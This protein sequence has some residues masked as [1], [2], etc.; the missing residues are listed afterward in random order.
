MQ[1]VISENDRAV[2]A[3]KSA[4]SDL[5]YAFKLKLEALEGNDAVSK[6]FL[7]QGY[8]GLRCFDVAKK[9]FGCEEIN[10]LAVD[11]TEFFEQR[12]DMN[13]FYAGAFSYAGGIKFFPDGKILSQAPP[14]TSENT[15]LSSAIPLSEEYS[16]AVFGEKYENGIELDPARISGALMRLC[17]YSMVFDA[18]N[19]DAPPKLV[20][21]DRSISGD[22][23]HISWKLREYIEEGRCRLTGLE[24]KFGT[25]SKTD[26]ELGRMLIRNDLLGLPVPRSQ[27]LK[28]ATI[29]LLLREGRPLGLEEIMKVFGLREGRKQKIVEVR[30]K[31][32]KDAFVENKEGIF[33]LKENMGQYFDRL[34]EG[35]RIYRDHILKNVDSGHPL[36]IKDPKTREDVW[37]TC[38]DLDYLTLVLITAILSKCWE[39]SILLLGIVKDSAANELVRTVV[40]ILEGSGLLPRSRENEIVRFD[41]D[42][43]LLQANSIVNGDRLSCPWRSFEYDV[44]FRTISPSRE[45][46]LTKGEAKVRGAY[47]NV[48]AAERTFVKA[49]FQLWSSSNNPSVR[50]HVFLYDRLCYPEYDNCS[51]AELILRNE[52]EIEEQVI[53]CLHFLNDTPLSD[54]V[55]GILHSM[56]EEPIPEALGHNYPL[57]LADKRAKV[58]YEEA[59]RSC[60]AAVDLEIT[61][62]R[63]DQQIL[64]QGKYRNLRSEIEN[65]RKKKAATQTK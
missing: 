48:I 58:A 13:V 26:L 23:A 24:T 35:T 12:L 8:D 6:L 45:N 34:L 54:L 29:A 60:V 2:E 22:I 44:C 42:T 43:M 30:T 17:E 65:S 10:Y 20:L 49:Y 50:S 41:S 64:F 55:M 25:I 37:L 27:F 38:E 14:P 32:F 56:G 15:S 11:G 57:F 28:F 3:V 1:N 7:R 52:Q 21:M 47:K 16:T 53:P 63:L 40:P 59:A 5:L 31:L 19:R 62:S 33:Q 51:P 18:I 9:F 46:S 36:R 61:K 39:N 4:A